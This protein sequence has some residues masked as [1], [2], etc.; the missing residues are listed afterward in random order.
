[1]PAPD[2]PGRGKLPRLIPLAQ[3]WIARARELDAMAL[4][5][6]D[7]APRKRDL[8]QDATRCRIM[9]SELGDAHLADR[10]PEVTELLK[11]VIEIDR[12]SRHPADDTF[13]A[14]GAWFREHGFD[15][16]TGEPRR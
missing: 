4:T 15:L 9:A 16:K 11:Q 6:R 1:M 13:A 2:A 3:R 5:Y 14:L 8:E 10:A 7:G 12:K